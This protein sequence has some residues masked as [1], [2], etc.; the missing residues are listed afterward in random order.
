MRNGRIAQ[1]HRYIE[2]N[3]DVA[4][5]TSNCDR[6]G[7]GITSVTHRVNC[8]YCMGCYPGCSQAFYLPKTLSG[9]ADAA[10]VAAELNRRENWLLLELATLMKS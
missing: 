4:T 6:C 1:T 7:A 10:A 8:G 5:S 9:P 3:L 2:P